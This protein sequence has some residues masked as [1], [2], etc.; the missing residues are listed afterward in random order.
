MSPALVRPRL[1]ALLKKR[2]NICAEM[3]LTDI[4]V[5]LGVSRERI[6]QLMPGYAKRRAAVVN[7]KARVAAFVEEHPEVTIPTW[8]GG[9]SYTTA[10]AALGIHRASFGQTMLLLGY[11]KQ[12]IHQTKAEREACAADLRQRRWADPVKR[13]KQLAATKRWQAEHPEQKR[14]IDRRARRKYDAKKKVAS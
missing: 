12:L 13:A 10:G 2:P 8:M 3:S 9:M 11:H 4:G 5:E 1:I 7:T 6:R 14:E